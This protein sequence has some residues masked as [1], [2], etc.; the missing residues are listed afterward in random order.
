M[1]LIMVG[2]PTIFGFVIIASALILLYLIWDSD[3]VAQRK[4]RR[5]TVFVLL[6]E[7]GLLIGTV[8]ITRF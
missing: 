7:A 2:L 8:A 5:L 6:V 1:R 3:T 4:K